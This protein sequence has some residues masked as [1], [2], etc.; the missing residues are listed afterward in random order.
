MNAAD[1]KS[2]VAEQIE[3]LERS[4]SL[5]AIEVTLLKAMTDDKIDDVE[6]AD[7]MKQMI[8]HLGTGIARLSAVVLN[9][10]KKIA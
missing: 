1:T 3:Q 7:G 6:L 5:S 10:L 9:T 2:Q 8:D 4:K